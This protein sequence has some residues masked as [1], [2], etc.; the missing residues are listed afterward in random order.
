MPRICLSIV[1]G[2]LLLLSGLATASEYRE[3]T[4]FADAAAAVEAYADQYGPECTLLVIDIDNTMLAM[5]EDLGSDQWF[6]WQEFLLEHEPD[7]PHLVAT[8]FGALLKAQ[9]VLFDRGKMR[10]PQ[11]DLPEMIQQ[12]QARGVPTLVL[13]SRGPDFR[14][15]TERELARNGYDFTGSVLPTSGVPRGEFLPYDPLNMSGVG[16]SSYEAEL[17]RLRAP[18]PASFANGVFMT[19]GQHKGAMLLTMLHKADRKPK[20][21]VFIDDHGRHVHR[22]Y[23]AMVRRGIETTVFH[24]HREDDNV[25]RFRYCDKSEVALRWDRLQSSRQD[26]SAH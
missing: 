8:D 15:A 4:D 14:A 9:G 20:A 25:K 26:S 19:A 24:Y 17:Y 23:D 10:P 11:P 5:E 13:T 12:L 1:P 3:T 21:V 22:V 16:L 2:L 7:S 6:E 18:R